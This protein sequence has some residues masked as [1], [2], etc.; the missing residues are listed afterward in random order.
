MARRQISLPVAIGII[1]VVLVIA[2]ALMWRKSSPPTEAVLR[3]WTPPPT[4]QFTPPSS[5]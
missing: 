3:E 2:L 4:P 1:A 5:R